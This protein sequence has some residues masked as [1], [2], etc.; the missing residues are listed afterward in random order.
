MDGALDGVVAEAVGVAEPGRCLVPNVAVCAFAIS[1]AAHRKRVSELKRPAP[2]RPLSYKLKK[3][4]MSNPLLT[5]RR[6]FEPKLTLR[7]S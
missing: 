1:A 6:A 5:L 4:S 2:R 3:K 7:R